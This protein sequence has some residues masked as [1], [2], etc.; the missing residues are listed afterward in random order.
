MINFFFLLSFLKEFAYTY[1]FFFYLIVRTSIFK[2][3]SAIEQPSIFEG[4]YK[5]RNVLFYARFLESDLVQRPF[6]Y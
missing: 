4:N 3:I 1:L 6:H 5:Y 2:I